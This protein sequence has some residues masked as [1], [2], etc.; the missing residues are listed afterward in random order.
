[1]NVSGYQSDNSTL[2][3]DRQL[4]GAVPA[5]GVLALLS[6][7]LL[8]TFDWGLPLVACYLG[9]L[10]AV[11][12]LVSPTIAYL[13]FLASIS[14]F[15]PYRLSLFWIHPFDVVFAL[16][17]G[18]TVLDFLLRGRTLV[19][20]SGY[21]LV[22]ALLILATLVSA[23][24]AYD[25]RLSVIPSL[26]I[27][28]VYLAF[29]LA[30][31]YGLKI[32]VRRLLLFYLVQA[33]LLSIVAFVQFALLGGQ[34]RFFGITGLALQYF[35][36]TA[37]PM[38]LAFLVWSE[39]RLARTAYGLMSIACGLGIFAT[40]SRA[41]FVAVVIAVP[42]LLVVAYRKSSREGTVRITRVVKQ[43]LAPV[44]LLAGGLLIM[45]ESLFVNTLGRIEELIAS[46]NEP[47]GTVA[48]RL[49]LWL[50]AFKAFL[51]NPVTGI[52][53]GNMR[54]V[55]Q[56][57]PEIRLEPLWYLVKGMSAH[58]VLLHY[59]AETGLLGTAA[60]VALFVKGLRTGWRAFKTRS[61]SV[62]SQVSAALFMA[63]F[64]CFLTML[65]MRAWTWGQGGYILALLFGLNAAWNSS[66]T[67]VGDQNRSDRSS[68]G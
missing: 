1:M 63:M 25:I 62:D 43:V 20:A 28:C 37:L 44:L 30:F 26:R 32:G 8:L 67:T 29:R 14:V 64:V 34:V 36:M 21:D 52:G 15:L 55:H 65:Y 10:A 18:A 48:R 46:I 49:V 17:L 9:A 50:A 19:R 7:I 68:T 5:L 4:S 53:I 31:L 59:L 23:L 45:E 42:V 51:A 6:P 61:S 38:A 35:A 24:F 66:R 56:V 47:Q 16:T 54:L 12:L 60:L 2:I 41:P 39:S 57:V 27:I 58:N 33:S 11:M 22:F 40:Q 3:A 13:V